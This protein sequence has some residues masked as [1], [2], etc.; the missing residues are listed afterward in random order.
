ML[1]VQ[2]GGGTTS[3]KDFYR[4]KVLNGTFDATVNWTINA[5]RM[6]VNEGGYIGVDTTNR[7]AYFYVDFINNVAGTSS[8][9]RKLADFDSALSSYLPKLATSSRNVLLDMITDESSTQKI[10][11][12]LGYAS[13][14][15][16]RSFACSYGSL[17]AVNDHYI[18]Y[19][20]W[21]Y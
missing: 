2:V 1:D 3:L 10:N 9:W 12:F 11:F 19:G 8:D 14:S 4:D 18:V 7:Q 5:G 6:T 21:T 17:I 20:S 13:S 15:N 16:P